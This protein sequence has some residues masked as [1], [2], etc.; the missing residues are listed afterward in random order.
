MEAGKP[1]VMPSQDKPGDE[2]VHIP[3]NFSFKDIA[4]SKNKEQNMNYL[5][6]IDVVLKPG[7]CLHVPAYWWY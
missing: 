1:F 3:N 5:K 2:E 4:L 6:V 7:D